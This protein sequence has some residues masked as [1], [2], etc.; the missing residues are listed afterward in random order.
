MSQCLC[1][2]HSREAQYKRLQRTGISVLLID[3]LFL[4]QLYPSR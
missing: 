4:A 3:D 1:G 2:A